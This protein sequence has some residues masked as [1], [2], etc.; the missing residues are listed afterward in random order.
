M[1]ALVIDS[2]EDTSDA[3]SEYLQNKGHMC[4]SVNNGRNALEALNKEEYD[5]TFLELDMPEFSGYDI[6]NAL[7]KTGRIN[8]Q[9]IVILTASGVIS[10]E[11]VTELK[12]KGVKSYF[13]KPITIDL[14]SNILDSDP[15]LEKSHL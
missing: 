9:N 6:I 1:N 13:K 15:K 3:L 5:I 14:L 8:K 4:I 2:D 10:D 7:Q 11:E 12:N